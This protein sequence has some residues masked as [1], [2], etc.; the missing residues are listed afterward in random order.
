MRWIPVTD[1]ARQMNLTPTR[2]RQFV[3]QGRLRAQKFGPMWMV[4]AAAVKS[5][6]PLKRG[7]PRKKSQMK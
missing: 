7:R 6:K 1:A 5:F 4:S 3:R 2:V